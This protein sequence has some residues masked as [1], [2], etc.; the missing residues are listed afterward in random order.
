MSDSLAVPGLGNQLPAPIPFPPAPWRSSGQ[1]WM[2]L[3]KTDV[4]PPAP[5]GLQRILNPRWLVVGLLQ[6][7]EGTLRYDELVFGGLARYGWRVGMFV[8]KIWVDDEASLWGGRRIW[9]LQKEMADFAWDGDTVRISDGQGL[10]TSL[11]VDRSAARLPIPWAPSPGLVYFDGRHTF[12]LAT[13]R[14]R[15]GK[16]GVR[17]DE[18]SERFSYRP[19]HKPLLSFG[20]RPFRMTVPAPKILRDER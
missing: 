8:Y 3:F 16:G 12:C 14:G 1:L 7:L 9:D 4:P 2:G 20:A 17:V 15:F 13:L 19:G 5:D 18:W 11:T 6:Y 10:I